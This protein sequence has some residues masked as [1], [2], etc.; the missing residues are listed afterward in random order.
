MVRRIQT[1][2]S[3][4]PR[5]AAPVIGLAALVLLAPGCRKPPD[6]A[7]A[8]PGPAPASAPAGA[9]AASS[10]VQGTWVDVRRETIRQYTPAVGSFRARQMT[11]LGPQVAG[12]VQEVLVNVGDVLRAG[13]ELVRLDPTFFEIEVKQ[14]QADLEAAT[15]KVQW[16]RETLTTLKADV[17][18]AR[19]VLA[20][21]ELEYTRMKNLW[22]KPSGETPS[23]PKQRFDAALFAY[24]QAQARLDAA[25]SRVGEQ[26]ARINE[27]TVG[28]TQAEE[29][30]RYAQQRL[31]ETTIRAPY[32]AVLVRRIVDPGEPV[33]ATPVSH[34]LEIQEIGTL[35]LEFSLP[36]ELL[37]RVRTGTAIRFDAEGVDENQGENKAA[38][39]VVFP[40]LDEATR[41]FR[42]RAVIPNPNGILRPGLLARVEAV[43]GEAADALVVPRQALRETARGWTVLISNDGHPVERPVEVGLVNDQWA[44]IRAGLSEGDRVL[45]P[46]AR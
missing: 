20:E 35:Y 13:Q 44:E 41:S 6:N 42:C 33:T 34:L 21:A 28:I 8:Q 27:M 26:E 23:I 31:K 7:S 25:Q 37:A 15:V 16:T 29:T 19:S 17:E 11:L 5:S 2:I 30:V 1:F 38:I 4:R 40:T 10:P 32:D 36:Q 24:R 43:T 12:R 18:V 9:S 46:S 22:E 45:L 14:R 3:E 39:D